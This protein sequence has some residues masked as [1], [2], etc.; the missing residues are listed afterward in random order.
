MK[1]M[2]GVEASNDIGDSA[3][4]V[5]SLAKRI[6]RF[7]A[8]GQ[9]NSIGVQ[10]VGLRLAS[11]INGRSRTDVLAGGTILAL[12]GQAARTVNSVI[13]ESEG[14]GGLADAAGWASGD[15]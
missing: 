9:Q 15:T 5:G 11:K 3:V 8:N 1:L 7:I 10:L 6:I 12:L 2:L 4:A 14:W 13:S